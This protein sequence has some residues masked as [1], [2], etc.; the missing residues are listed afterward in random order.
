MLYFIIVD[1]GKIEVA[2]NV[3]YG[4]KLK[5]K[6]YETY[7]IEAD[8]EVEAIEKYELI[9]EYER[10]DSE[11]ESDH[12]YTST[13]N[14]IS[15][16][17]IIS[18]NKGVITSTVVVGTHIF[19][20]IFASIRDIV[21]GKAGGYI[22][23]IDSIKDESLLDLKNKARDLN[24]NAIIGIS[25]DVDEISGGGKSMLMVT[26]IGTAITVAPIVR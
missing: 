6:G 12:V 23:T 16:G 20:D 22:D 13:T 17:L 8:S 14:Y 19:K 4:K 7:E 10:R 2:T 11:D 9:E 25:V 1:N 5:S 24:C 3:A 21:G 26:T 18:D 15:D